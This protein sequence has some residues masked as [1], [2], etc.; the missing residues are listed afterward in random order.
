M[1]NTAM[2]TLETVEDQGLRFRASTGSGRHTTVDSGPGMV[3]P[4]PVEMLLVS[5]G[6]CEG[7]DVISILRK[8]RQRVTGYQIALS[9][10]RRPEHPRKYVRIQ[11][12]HRLRGRYRELLR[13]EIAQ[14]VA[15]P[16]D[17]DEELQHLMA[18]LAA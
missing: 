8:K 4:S 15:T 16:A 3:A 11:V 13:A 6:G 12:V 14:T 2:L 17:V 18:V 9:G 7:M 5:L 10:E 1:A